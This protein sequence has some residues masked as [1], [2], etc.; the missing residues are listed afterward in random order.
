MRNFWLSDTCL[1]RIR[2]DV[3]LRRATWVAIEFVDVAG[4]VP[5]TSSF[6]MRISKVGS[7]KQSAATK[8]KKSM[9]KAGEFAERVRGTAGASAVDSP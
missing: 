7:S 2:S 5:I 9:A 3:A 4:L 6:Q 1:G 8:K